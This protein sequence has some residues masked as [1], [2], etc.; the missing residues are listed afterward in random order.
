MRLLYR[1]RALA[2]HPRNHSDAESVKCA[3][4]GPI[5]QREWLTLPRRPRHYALRAAY[6][7][8]LWVLGVTAWQALYG[9]GHEPTLGDTSRFGPFLFRLYCY[10]ELTLLLFFAAL[11]SASAIA[12]EK[13]R[14]T[15]VLLLLTDLRNHEIVLGKLFGATLQVGLFLSLSIPL[16]ALLILLGGISVGAVLQ[17]VLIMAA[18][19]LAAGSLGGLMALWR[20]R[21]FQSLALTVILTVMYLVA[22]RGL[23]LLPWT[24]RS[25]GQ[26]GLAWAA[27]LDPYL[28]I[29]SAGEQG[30]AVPPAFGFVAVML[31]A[32]AALNSVGMAR[33]RKWNPSGEPIIQRELGPARDA[34]PAGVASKWKSSTIKVR[35][36]DEIVGDTKLPAATNQSLMEEP[37][38][39]DGAQPVPA[40][41]AGTS[42]VSIH[43]APGKTREV[44][45]NPI[46]WREI[47]TRAY[48]RR[49]LLVKLSYLLVLGLFLYYCLK[50][51]F[52]GEN[53]RHDF[54][55]AEGLVPVAVLSLLLISAQAVTAITS[56]RDTGALDLLL[57][58]DLSAKEFI[59]GKLLG[60]WYNAKEY[61]LPPLILALVYCLT[62]RLATPPVKH[63]ELGTYR[64]VESFLCVSGGLI[65]LLLFA[66]VLGIHVALRHQNSRVAIANTLG[67]IFFL[68]IGTLVCIYLILIN[69]Q[70]FESQLASF[71]LFLL[72]GI[73]GLWWVLNAGRAS[74]ALTLASW[75]C[76]V[77]VLYAVTNILVGKPGSTEST[78]ALMPFAVVAVAFGFTLTAMLI[79]LVSEFDIALGR[80]TGGAD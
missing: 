54:M 69:G 61:V 1:P 28:A 9:W 52:G 13:D 80:T 46:L 12:Q 33:L 17:A 66:S 56:E 5:F 24:V 76:P 10:V 41:T 23:A 21:T 58:T 16:M 20:E 18:A 19:G 72:A 8:A 57:V 27:W 64:N 30:A 6:L 78:D 40:M 3:V 36:P 31:L 73:G 38:N 14:R 4:L 15:F 35:N 59:F 7:G 2:V 11:T 50:P 44:W 71:V 60:I 47:R 67:T 22:A 63:Q 26:L 55:A 48:G 53:E 74:A 39:Q 49:P 45:D 75:L 79:P 29:Q 34:L 65:L 51:I 42:S 25:Q 77:A 37:S 68:T 70:R 43:A 32:A 62:H